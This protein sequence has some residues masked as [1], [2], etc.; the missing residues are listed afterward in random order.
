M[1]GSLSVAAGSGLTY[2]SG[3]GQF[4]TSS[5]P[6]AQLA[7]S[8]VTFGSTAV[9]L[10]ASATTFTGLASITSTAVVTNDSGFRIR[11]NSDNT[12]ILAFDL[13]SISG[14]TT[15]T[16]TVP[17]ASDTLVFISSYTDINK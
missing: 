2:N 4:G 11:N 14:S 8:T 10:G 9:A 7:N 15:R 16:L 5:I 6:N 13:A 3:T 17:D 12:K 1:L